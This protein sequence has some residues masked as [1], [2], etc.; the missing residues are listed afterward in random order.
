MPMYNLIEYCVNY[1]KT[2]EI[3]WQFY[4]DVPA[5]DNDGEITNFTVN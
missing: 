5:L 3:L 1:L 2:S 4:I